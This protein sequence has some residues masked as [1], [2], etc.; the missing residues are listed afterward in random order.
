[1]SARFALIAVLCWAVCGATLSGCNDASP[2]SASTI[3]PPAESAAEGTANAESSQSN[4][5]T[6]AQDVEQP[7][8]NSPLTNT[9]R[10]TVPSTRAESTMA[11][12]LD[13]VKS[14]IAHVAAKTTEDAQQSTAEMAAEVKN[15]ATALVDSTEATLSVSGAATTALSASAESA[16]ETVE[17]AA[18]DEASEVAT[19]TGSVEN[20]L[21]QD[22]SAVAN[23]VQS[24]M[25]LATTTAAVPEP[26][27][28]DANA[29]SAAQRKP[30]L[31]VR[32]LKAASDAKLGAV[33]P[34][35]P[36]GQAG[37]KVGDT[38]LAIG[39]RKMASFKDVLQLVAQRKAGDTI[40]VVVQRGADVKAIPVVLGK[41]KEAS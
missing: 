16:R 2:S 7:E 20:T 37:L 31:G 34:D 10:Q 22:A 33:Y 28:Q 18:R 17:E 11:S 25:S 40:I 1:M 30:L 29:S 4:V 36:A 15:T 23:Q 32:H 5:A 3:V 19:L 35:G 26:S 14:D 39:D 12:A 6:A 21:P 8:R 27:A 41:W 13:A 38:I 24:A 9:D